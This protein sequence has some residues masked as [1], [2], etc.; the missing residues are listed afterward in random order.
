MVVVTWIPLSLTEARGFPLYILSYTSNDDSSTGS[1][2]TTSSSVKVLG[3]D[4]QI[5]Y[6]FTIQ[7]STG[8]GDHTG[9]P[10]EGQY[11]HFSTPEDVSGGC[12]DNTF[13]YILHY[14]SSF[15]SVLLAVPLKAFNGTETTN[16]NN[17]I[18]NTPVAVVILIIF[19]MV[20]IRA[21]IVVGVG[22]RYV[23]ELY[24]TCSLCV[25]VHVCICMLQYMYVFVCCCT[26][27]CT[28]L[29]LYVYVFVCC[30]T[31]MCLHVIVHVYMCLHVCSCTCMCLC[32]TYFSV[33]FL[34]MLVE[35]PVHIGDRRNLNLIQS[36]FSTRKTDNFNAVL[37][38]LITH[39]LLM[40]PV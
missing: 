28:C 6:L 38:I 16:R 13:P 33:L 32:I 17:S 1:V 36:W 39:L 34:L 5:G 30:C 15:L 18:V 4:P 8:N 7:A 24:C 27:V 9:Q 23:F 10:T 21:V 26:C 3:L 19:L 25:I 22:V 12:N 35:S 20:A 2:N 14:T 11:M 29:L 40:R 31:C 37:F